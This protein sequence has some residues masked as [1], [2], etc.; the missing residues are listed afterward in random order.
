MSLN[1]FLQFISE[2]AHPMMFFLA[3]DVSRNSM[4]IR[5][6][7]RECAIATAPGELSLDDVVAVN[8]VRRA[9]LEE[10]HYV[11]NGAASWQIDQ[12][13]NMIGVHVIDLHVDLLF[14]CVI[15]QKS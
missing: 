11:F 5:F 9:S 6:G 7:Y 2:R 1:E 8:P 14:L 4:Q 12:R 15:G 13:V 10:L 3:G